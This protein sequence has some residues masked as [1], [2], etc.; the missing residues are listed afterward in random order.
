MAHYRNRIFLVL[1]ESL[2]AQRLRSGL[3][4]GMHSG[5]CA[6]DPGSVPGSASGKASQLPTYGTV[7]GPLEQSESSRALVLTGY[8]A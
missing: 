2:P 4:G 8:G 5:L 6:G 3:P 7:G 1:M